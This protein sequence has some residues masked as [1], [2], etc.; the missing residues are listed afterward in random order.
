MSFSA[1]VTAPCCQRN[2]SNECWVKLR[3][4]RWLDGSSSSGGS[5]RITQLVTR[6]T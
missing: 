5:P 3:D 4:D 6:P 2:V 1:Y